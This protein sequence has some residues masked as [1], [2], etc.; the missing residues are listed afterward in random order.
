LDRKCKR[1]KWPPIGQLGIADANAQKH[2]SGG[3]LSYN[4]RVNLFQASRRGAGPSKKIG[5]RSAIPRGHN[6]RCEQSMLRRSSTVSKT[7][8]SWRVS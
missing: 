6:A 1:E 5:K 4:G 8:V 2:V 3:T 7:I